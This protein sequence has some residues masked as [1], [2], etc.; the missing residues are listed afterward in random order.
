MTPPAP[1]N[2]TSLRFK[3]NIAILLTW[4]I[5]VLF[6]SML[7]YPYE[8]RRSQ[9]RLDDVQALLSAV[10]EQRKTEL[11]NEIF[12]GQTAALMS[13]IQEIQKVKDIYQVSVFD[14]EGRIVKSTSPYGETHL[15]EDHRRA[16]DASGSL[17]RLQAHDADGQFGAAIQ[18][19][20]EKMGY[21]KIYFDL[22]SLES[23][24]FFQVM[25]FAVLCVSMLGIMIVVLNLTLFYCVIRPASILRD[26]IIRV[27]KGHLGHQVALKTTDEIGDMTNAFNDMSRR[28]KEQKSSVI[29]ASCAS[30]AYALKLEDSNRELERLNIRLEDMVEER[31]AKLRGINEKLQLE[32]NERRRTDKEKKELEERLARSQKMEALGL[33]AGGV[34]HDLNNVLTAVVSLPDLLLME[35]PPD[36]PF[37]KSIRTIQKSGKKAAAIVQDLLTLARRGV[38]NTEVLNLNRHIIEDYLEA[39]EFEKLCSYHPKVR[40]TARPDPELLNIRGSAIHLKKTLMNLVSNAAEAQPNG[41]TICIS[42]ENRFLDH[43]LKGYDHVEKGDYAVLRVADKGGG[44]PLEDMNRIFE[45]FYT[46]K[47]MGRSGTGLG[48]A[49][50]WGTVQDHMG[51]IDIETEKGKGTAFDLYFPVCRQEVP[52]QSKVEPLESY[53]GRGQKILV[54]DDME[55]Q[56]EIAAGMLKR[57]GYEVETVSS[58][59][60][61]VAYLKSSRADVII[62]DMIMEPGIDGLETFRRIVAEHPGQKAIIASGFAENERVKEA[63]SLG[64]GVYVRKPYTL[65]KIGLAVKKELLRKDGLVW[66]RCSNSKKTDGGGNPATGSAAG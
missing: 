58:G 4:A 57:L 9:S 55:E 38:T 6:F 34:A 17:V 28:L 49:V 7:L 50:V 59:E 41:G 32:I 14:L 3:I 11:A 29:Q 25:L 47:V 24:S 26:A 39:P 22:S 46:R 2:T 43:P 40:V 53:M 15:T 18:I 10:Y 64:A 1:S 37:C 30:E 42:T 52:E 36:S 23:E 35:V 20:G 54:V 44:I 66:P 56:T 60:E 5:L 62:L 33:L 16:M 63:Q 61:A 13:S 31:T 19:I 8:K 21:I 45:P 48:M 51:Y 65:K 12:A 27:Q